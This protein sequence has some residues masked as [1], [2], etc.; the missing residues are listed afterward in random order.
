MKKHTLEKIINVLE[1]FPEENR[2]TVPEQYIP[3]IRSILETM[4]K[5]RGQGPAAPVDVHL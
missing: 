4:N 5:V 3:H 2:V 1:N